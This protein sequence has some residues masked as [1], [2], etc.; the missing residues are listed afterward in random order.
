MIQL[1]AAEEQPPSQRIN[2]LSVTGKVCPV[3]PL[4]LPLM[5]TRG[6]QN[7]VGRSKSQCLNYLVLGKLEILTPE[8][9]QCS[10]ASGVHLRVLLSL[11]HKTI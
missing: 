9:T 3:L 11:Q 8:H 6:Q 4:L 1:W 7:S 5:A 10:L 2:P